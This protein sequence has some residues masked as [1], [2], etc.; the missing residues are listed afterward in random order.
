MF[1]HRLALEPKFKL[2]SEPGNKCPSDSMRSLSTTLPELLEPAVPNCICPLLVPPVPAASW[3]IP[4]IAE[5]IPPAE[6][7]NHITDAL[8][9]VSCVFLILIAA[10]FQLVLVAL[11]LD[12]FAVNNPSDEMRSFSVLLPLSSVWN[13]REDA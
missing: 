12:R 13:T 11:V 2:L 6:F 3:W 4:C 8:L 9:S 1:A 7:S 5:S 10:P